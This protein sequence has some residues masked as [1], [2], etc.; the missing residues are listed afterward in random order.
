M[1]VCLVKHLQWRDFDSLSACLCEPFAGLA[2]VY[3]PTMP[4]LS[5]L[6]RRYYTSAA[7][8]FGETPQSRAL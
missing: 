7:M 2:S 4:R 8:I 1:P 3:R 5:L 6:G